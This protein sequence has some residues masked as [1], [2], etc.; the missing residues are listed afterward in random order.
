MKGSLVIRK[1]EKEKGKQKYV[2]TIKLINTQF[3]VSLF[4]LSPFLIT[5]DPFL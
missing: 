2:S 4:P 3:T 5:N 1:E